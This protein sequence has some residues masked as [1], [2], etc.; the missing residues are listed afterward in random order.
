[1]QK[2]C[3]A[4]LWQIMEKK[5]F[6]MLSETEELAENKMISI[7]RNYETSWNIFKTYY[8]DNLSQYWW[9]NTVYWKFWVSSSTAFLVSW[10]LRN[11]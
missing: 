3:L 4:F 8:V 1:M 10:H 2:N 6:Y 11:L 5:T 7:I 9:S